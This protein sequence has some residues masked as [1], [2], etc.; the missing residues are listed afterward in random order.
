MALMDIP[1]KGDEV[2]PMSRAIPHEWTA[3]RRAQRAERHRRWTPGTRV[4]HIYLR[5]APP[6]T[7]DRR[8]DD[9]GAWSGIE[10]GTGH[11]VGVFDEQ[12]YEETA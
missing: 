10:D 12:P 9:R 2:S 1:T 8:D 3:D 11:R 6:V 5:T 7:L 4:R